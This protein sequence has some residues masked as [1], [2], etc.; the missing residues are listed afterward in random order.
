MML[1]VL[2]PDTFSPK[3]KQKLFLK[4]NFHKDLQKNM[5]FLQIIHCKRKV[6]V[7]LRPKKKLCQKK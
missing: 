6:L 2:N 4:F 3:I 7:P 1:N 5:R